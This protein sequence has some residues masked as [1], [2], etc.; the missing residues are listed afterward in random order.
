MIEDNNVPNKRVCHA[1]APHTGNTAD[2]HGT[3]EKE[4]RA[5]FNDFSEHMTGKAI[6]KKYKVS[7]GAVVAWKRYWLAT[8]DFFDEPDAIRQLR[9][10]RESA[11]AEKEAKKHPHTDA[12][13]IV[14][15]VA[16]ENKAMAPTT[17][18]LD[19]MRL[20]GLDIITM[21]MARIEELIPKTK[22]IAKLAK[23]LSVVL[24]YVATKKEDA[25]KNSI[26]DIEKR[27]R[28]FV[29]NVVNV[30]NLNNTNNKLISENDTGKIIELDGDQE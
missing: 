11:L 8:L 2:M 1:R 14:A 6:A 4:Y 12:V 16:K 29:M 22:D 24:P 10:A 26:D 7:E 21:S 30:Y 17:K 27:R 3:F 18:N 15:K 20:K 5:I 28:D 19:L 25:G 23:V 9:E 13:T